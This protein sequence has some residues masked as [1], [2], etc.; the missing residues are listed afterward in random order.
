MAKYEFTPTEREWSFGEDEIIVSKTDKI[1]RID[2]ANDV[3]LRI[4]NL[5]E[6]EVVGQPHSLVRHPDMPTRNR[7]GEP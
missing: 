6:P 4:A 5:T 1:G 7:E 2:Y 3:F